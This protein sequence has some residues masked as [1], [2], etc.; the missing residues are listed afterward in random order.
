MI[1]MKAPTRI[2][3]MPI[4]GPKMAKPLV[5]ET[6]DFGG[7]AVKAHKAKAIPLSTLSM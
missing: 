2:R 3:A 5:T 6:T 1:I 7:G 4:H